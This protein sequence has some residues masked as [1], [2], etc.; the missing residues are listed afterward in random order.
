MAQEE[1]VPMDHDETAGEPVVPL[2]E[3]RDGEST[4][5]WSARLTP[6]ERQAFDNNA[7]LQ[8]Y[9]AE[10]LASLREECERAP[11]FLAVIRQYVPAERYEAFMRLLRSDAL[12][13]ALWCKLTGSPS[14]GASAGG[15]AAPADPAVDWASIVGEDAEADRG[16][17][18]SDES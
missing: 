1:K 15:C 18:G 17:I 10:T 6:A 14:G 3:R 2:P 11:D 13:E 12:Q 9:L 7:D 4:E 5:E 8:W 16:R